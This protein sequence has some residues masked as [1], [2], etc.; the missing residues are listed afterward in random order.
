MVNEAM[1]WLRDDVIVMMSAVVL[2]VG[3]AAER[4]AVGHGGR[5]HLP[6]P[7]LCAVP[8]SAAGEVGRG[9]V[10]AAQSLRQRLL[11]HLPSPHLPASPGRQVWHRTGP[12]HPK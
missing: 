7:V 6:V 12:D 11:G 3:A 8:G 9:S 2:C 4:V 10:P 5:V 1:N